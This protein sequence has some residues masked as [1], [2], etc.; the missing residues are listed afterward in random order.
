VLFSVEFTHAICGSQA[1]THNFHLNFI[2]GHLQTKKFKD[3][4]SNNMVAWD[5]G[6]GEREVVE[7]NN[8]VFSPFLLS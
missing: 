8:V 1:G 5:G 6:R 3:L 4:H 7:V 2:S